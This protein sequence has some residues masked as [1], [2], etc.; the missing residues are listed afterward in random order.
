MKGVIRCLKEV[1][2]DPSVLVPDDAEAAVDLYRDKTAFIF[3]G[4]SSTFGAF[5]ARATL[6][7][8]GRDQPC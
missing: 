3:E 7:E 5:D 1:D 6:H 8:N 4:Q 2:T